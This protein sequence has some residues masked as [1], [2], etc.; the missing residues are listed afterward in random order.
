MPAKARTALA[1]AHV[2]GTEKELLNF[3]VHPTPKC[4]E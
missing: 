2:D 1:A 3:V 4:V